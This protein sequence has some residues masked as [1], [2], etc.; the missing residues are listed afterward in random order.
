[1]VVKTLLYVKKGD[2]FLET[3]GKFGSIHHNAQLFYFPPIKAQN[4][5][6]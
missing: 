5:K 4:V 2:W 1:M 6:Q 3:L